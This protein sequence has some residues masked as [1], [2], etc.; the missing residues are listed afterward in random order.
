MAFASISL[1]IT[2]FVIYFFKTEKQLYKEICD[3]FF[4][5]YFFNRHGNNIILPRYASNISK[6]RI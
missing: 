2:Y 3:K 1:L 5:K 4:C 6:I